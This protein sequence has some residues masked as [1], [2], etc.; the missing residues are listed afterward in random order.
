MSARRADTTGKAPTHWHVARHMVRAATA[1]FPALLAVLGVGMGLYHWVEERSW[2]DS[3]LSAAMILSGM[4]P[5][6]DVGSVAGKWLIGTYALFAG[7]VFIVLA[8][9]MLSPVV[10]HLLERVRLDPD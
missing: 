2:P 8:G 10:H 7:L 5:V 9:V 1:F 6:G 3:F 4:G